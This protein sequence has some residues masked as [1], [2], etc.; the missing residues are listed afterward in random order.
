MVLSSGTT[1]FCCPNVFYVRYPGLIF[2]FNGEFPVKPVFCYRIAVGKIGS[3][4]EF[5]F[6]DTLQR[7]LFYQIPDV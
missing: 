2:P 4:L 7:C 5:S 6:E 1:P 3:H